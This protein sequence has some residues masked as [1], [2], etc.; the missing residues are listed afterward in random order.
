MYVKS[1]GKFESSDW[2]LHS[3]DN[4]PHGPSL[5]YTDNHKTCIFFLK[6]RKF[7]VIRFIPSDIGLSLLSW[8]RENWHDTCHIYTATTLGQY[9][10][11]E[12]SPHTR[13]AGKELLLTFGKW[14]MLYMYLWLIWIPE[15]SILVSLHSLKFFLHEDSQQGLYNI[16]KTTSLDY[17][18][19]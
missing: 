16:W 2:F 10:F 17:Q 1:G 12:L 13:L 19:N 9:I 8:A 3:Q 18:E 5:F 15:Q 6:A 11:P 14:F 4:L 7:K